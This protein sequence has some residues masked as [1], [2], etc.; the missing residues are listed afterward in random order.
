MAFPFAKTNCYLN[1]TKT[2]LL[3]KWPGHT[4]NGV[5]NSKD[6]VSGIDLTPT[7]LDM[8]GLPALV[9]VDGKSF[10]N[11]LNGETSEDFK[12]VFTVFNTTSAK[13]KYPMRCIVDNEYGYILNLWHDGETKF[14]NESQAGLTF[15][16]MAKAS[17]DND[18][19]KKRTDLF[20][21]RVPEELY[22]FKTD[23]DSLHNLV[24]DSEYESI[25][26][27][28]RSLLLA[29]MENTQDFMIQQA[30]EFINAK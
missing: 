17:I 5:I 20:E 1:S 11:I 18:E 29:Y 25:A 27:K 7:I 9:D 3:V 15:N 21:F 12:E 8:L 6:M 30:T 26:K 16:A 2:P 28:M 4:K 14:K 23:P 10:A 22:N 13:R 19:I 24:N